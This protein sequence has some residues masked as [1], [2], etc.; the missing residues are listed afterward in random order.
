MP[1]PVVEL[2][3]APM[4]RFWMERGLIEP[5]PAPKDLG[6]RLG[7]WLDVRQAIVLHQVLGSD[8]DALA[9]DQ[10]R[11]ADLRRQTDDA[12]QSLRE[13]IGMDR[14]AP[15]LWRN[16]MPIEVSWQAP[17]WA[18]CW[19]PYRRYMV[20]HQK[21]IGWVLS[22]LRRRLREALSDA[23]GVSHALAQMDAVFDQTLT[24]KEARVLASLPF[25][26]EHRLLA[27]MKDPDL[28]QPVPLQEASPSN[29][30]PVDHPLKPG[31]L[32]SFEHD[33]RQSLLT[34]L[35]LR[36]QPVFGLLDALQA[37]CP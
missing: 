27:L 3:C 31:W 6:A 37:H 29:T 33:I 19:E 1:S 11:A 13:A 28:R 25:K 20:D 15:G 9:R 4:V 35:H 16:P 14:F 24:P 32:L 12:L 26:F 17:V 18:E 23:G 7:A 34:E 10:T 36:S 21:Q 30:R 22:R 5:T 8:T 2:Q